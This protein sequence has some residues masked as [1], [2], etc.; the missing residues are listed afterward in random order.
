MSYHKGLGQL[1][2]KPGGTTGTSTTSTDRTV[3]D[4]TAGLR[5]GGDIASGII[6]AF[7]GP[8]TPATTPVVDETVYY[9]PTT[10]PTESSWTLPIVV[11]GIALLGIGA[12][13]MLRKKPVSANRRR[14]V[15]RN[16]ASTSEE[17]EAAS[18]KAYRERGNSIERAG[19]HMR[20]SYAHEAAAKAYE[21]AGHANIAAYHR[22]EAAEHVRRAAWAA[23]RPVSANRR[24]RVRR[25]YSYEHISHPYKYGAG[26]R[27]VRNRR[28]SRR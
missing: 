14:R 16:T 5:A 24:R 6:T 18:K 27:P 9:T 2:P 26:G 15:K 8:T 28:R 17:A 12:F 22:R 11:G 19:N 13:V 7:R 1:P 21:A 23:G 3:A 10:S 25:N 20:A 4:W